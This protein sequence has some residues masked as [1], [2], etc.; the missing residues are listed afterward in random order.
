MQ[1]LDEVRSGV[2]AIGWLDGNPDQYLADRGRFKVMGTGFL[3]AETTAMTNRHVVQKILGCQRNHS[4]PQDR[5]LLLFTYPADSGWKEAFCRIK[6]IGLTDNANPDIGFIEFARRPEPEFG[7]CKPLHPADL[8]G[9]L[10]GHHV[11][12]F[13][14]PY[15]N[16]S[17]TIEVRDSEGEVLERIGRF[18]PILQK[19]YISATTPF[20]SRVSEAE[21]V[22]LDMRI[23]GGM[24]GS[25]VFDLVNGKVVGI[26]YAGRGEGFDGT[27]FAV[28]VPLDETRIMN[29]LRVYRQRQEEAGAIKSSK[30]A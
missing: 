1:M 24:S 12:A 13:G 20:G 15:G 30:S 11:A 9:V 17:L 29:W 7:Q 21:R 26:I 22:L 16:E 19:G 14:F 10:V 2:C 8:S 4:V 6:G 5:L 28:A 27:V 18:G 23:A 3:I 25:P